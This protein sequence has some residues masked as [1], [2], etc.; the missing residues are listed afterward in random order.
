VLDVTGHRVSTLVDGVRA[1]AGQSV[2]WNGRRSDG[3]EA[4]PGV[5]LCRLQG[6]G[7]TQTGRILRIQ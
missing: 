6:A 4:A 7:V 3:S 5:Y 2:V 1:G